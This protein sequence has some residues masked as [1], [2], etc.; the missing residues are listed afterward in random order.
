MIRSPAMGLLS[1]LAFGWAFG[2]TVG[3]APPAMTQAPAPPSAPAGPVSVDAPAPPAGRAVVQDADA[4]YW[5]TIDRNKVPELRAY[6][7]AYPNG[8]FAKLAKI[9]IDALERGMPP[10]L[11]TKDDKAPTAEPK[12]DS[13]TLKADNPAPPATVSGRA[14]VLDTAN[15]IVAG[16]TVAL[17]GVIGERAPYDK[18]LG[19]YI[20]QQ[21]TVSCTAKEATGK[22]VCKTGQGFDIARAALFNGA[23]QAAPDAPPEYFADQEKARTDRVGI[24]QAGGR[25]TGEGKSKKGGRR[26]P[27]VRDTGSGSGDDELPWLKKK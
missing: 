17:F 13:E 18:Q 22:Y 4:L 15:L 14:Q 5:Q 25:P 21:G 9:R 11:E 3:W 7:E 2:W 6:L 1:V 10:P 16:K 24:W 26:P 19:D 8:K 27:G 20:A 23:A 12:K